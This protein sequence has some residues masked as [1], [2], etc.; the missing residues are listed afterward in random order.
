MLFIFYTIKI[1]SKILNDIVSFKKFFI[2]FM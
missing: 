1:K 2:I